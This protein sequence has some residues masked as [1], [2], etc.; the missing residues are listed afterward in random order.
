M[1]PSRKIH[2]LRH[3]QALHNG[4]KN[5]PE[6][7]PP[8]T[9][10]GLKQA[11]AVCLNFKPDLI[12][13]SPMTRTIQT[14]QQVLS[15]MNYLESKNIPIEIWPSL[16]EVPDRI[17]NVGLSRAALTL[18]Y[19]SLDF[20]R[21]A[22]EWDYKSFTVES[23]LRRA[24]EVLSELRSRREENILLVG[25]CA[26]ISYLVRMNELFEN[27]EL[28]SYEFD[29]TGNLVQVEYVGKDKQDK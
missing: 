6:R 28:R 1:E 19:P 29:S 22:E 13:C 4:H 25:H 20:S 8:L 11:A 3:G 26:F 15:T 23:T 7:D 2:I 5:Y 27:C 10:T 18:K 21:C 24:E 14:M 9:E 16:R 12:I 17:F